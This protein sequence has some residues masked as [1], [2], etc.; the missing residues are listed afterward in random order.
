MLYS[1]ERKICR[2]EWNGNLGRA[3]FADEGCDEIIE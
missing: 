2:V 3:R 1:C